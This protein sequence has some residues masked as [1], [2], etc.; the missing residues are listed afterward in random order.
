MH[1]KTHNSKW[2]TTAFP[3][4]QNKAASIKQFLV[5]HAK[6]KNFQEFRT[7]L[8]HYRRGSSKPQNKNR[9]NLSKEEIKVPK[10]SEKK[11]PKG[12]ISTF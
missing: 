12:K 4:R 10:T 8:H 5:P 9:K 2:Q 11:S 6:K 3:N 1:L 7:F